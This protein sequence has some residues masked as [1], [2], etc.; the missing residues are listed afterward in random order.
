MFTSLA[1][2][3]IGIR[4][5]FEEALTIASNAG[6]KGLDIGIKDIAGRIADTSL[7]AVQAQFESA[8]VRP[9]SWGLPVAWNGSDDDYGE[10]LKEL[11]GLAKVA[12]SLGATRCS[13][14]IP[15][16]SAERPFRENFRWHVQRL[17]PICEI[18]AGEGCSLGLEFIGPRTM[19]TEAVYGFIYSLEGML[20]LC[21]AIGTGNAGLLLDCWHWYTSLGTIADLK[22]LSVDDVVTVHVNDA[23]AGVSIVDHIDNQRALPSETGVIDL[24]GFLTVLKDLGYEGPVTPE[25]FSERVRVLPAEQAANET[26]EGLDRAWQAA[27]IAV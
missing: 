12:A 15:A 11:A 16:A 2:G 7:E 14:W 6:F 24:V 21:E 27:G 3:A 4:A 10:T 23:P 25:P 8:A 9:A 22:A 26:F 17:K 18:L 5:S 13:Q 20:G 1:P 19:R